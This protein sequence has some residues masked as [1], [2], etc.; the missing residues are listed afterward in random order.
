MTTEM[1]AAWL[2]VCNARELGA[3]RR[4]AAAESAA[5]RQCFAA[6]VAAAEVELGTWRFARAIGPRPEALTAFADGV[7]RACASIARRWADGELLDP[8]ISHHMATCGKCAMVQRTMTEAAYA[9]DHLVA[10]EFA[11]REAVVGS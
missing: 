3:A 8:R 2:V 5:R 10:D 9:A 11:A 4:L 6:S 7:V 1:I